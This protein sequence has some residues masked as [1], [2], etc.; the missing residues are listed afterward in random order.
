MSIGRYVIFTLHHTFSDNTFKWYKYECNRSQLVSAIAHSMHGNRHGILDNIVDSMDEYTSIGR[1]DLSIRLKLRDASTYGYKTVYYLAKYSKGELVKLDINDI[2]D[3]VE[4]A[5]KKLNIKNEKSRKQVDYLTRLNNSY[6]FRRGPVPHVHNRKYHRG[7][8]HR[9]PA[10]TKTIRNGYYIDE[11]Y[12]FDNVK[13]KNLP[14]VYDDIV[15][16]NERSWKQNKK[17]KKQWMKNVN[18]HTE[19]VVINKR[20]YDID[21]NDVA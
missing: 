12:A 10:T 11:D 13:I 14:T 9:H 1:N 5:F 17:A 18:K 19:T 6:E 7:C 21:D 4:E 15:R 3:E 8:Y 2:R 20:T 16:H